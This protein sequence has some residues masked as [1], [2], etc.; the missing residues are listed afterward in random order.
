MN[1]HGKVLQKSAL[2]L[3]VSLALPSLAFAQGELMLEEIIVTAQ[4]RE[5]SLQDVP[6]SVSVMSGD[7]IT[8]VGITNLDEMSG[9]IPN[10]SVSEGS[11]SVSITMRG[12][13]SG[14]N[15]GFEQSVGM[16]VD[17]I[18]AGRDRQFRS[19]FM[20]V[21]SVE[22]LRGPQGTLFGKNTIAG[23]LNIRTAKPTEDFEASLRGSYE[24]ESD[25]YS[26]EGI[27]SG[28]ISDTLMGRLAVK[29]LE[30]DGFMHNTYTGE[31]ESMKSELI[32][33]GTL[34]WEPTDLLSVITKFETAHTAARGEPNRLDSDGGWDELYRLV[35]EDFN[36]ND[37][38]QRSTDLTDEN[39]NDSD[40]LTVTVD[41]DLNE[42]TLTSITGYS[43][44]QDYVQQDVDFSPL[45]VLAQYQDQKFDQLSQE[46][47]ITSPL[48]DKFDFLAGAYY[49]K[50]TLENHKRLDSN[51]ASLVGGVP[52]EVN[53]LGTMLPINGASVADILAPA[54]FVTKDDGSVGVGNASGAIYASAISSLNTGGGRVSDYKQDAET[55]SI[56][57]QGTWHIE[58]NL[59]LTLGLRYAEETK[60]ASRTLY[61][62]DYGTENVMDLEDPNNSLVLAIQNGV[63]G[64]VNHS[65]AAADT[66]ENLSPSIKLQYE[67]NDEVMFYASI[68]QAF[69]S[70]GYSESGTSADEY[71]FGFA[72]E[73]ALAFEF[74]SKMSVMD[75]RG[76]INFALF[77][78]QYDDLQVSAFIGDRYVVGN[79]AAAT[80]QGL[81]VDGVFRLTESIDLSGSFAYLDA[82]YDEFKTAACTT[83]QA[84]A[85]G[86]PRECTQDLSGKTLTNAPEFSA[87]FGLKHSADLGDNYQL[88]STLMANYTA[89]Q[90]LSQ[91]LDPD[92][93]E[94]SHVV[95]SAR[96]AISSNEDTWE[97]ALVG[98]NLTN[99]AIRGY[100]AAV[101]L[102]DG[103]RF[104]Y[105]AAPRTLAVQFLVNY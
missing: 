61:L 82:T 44:Y 73:E 17:G 84:I 76:T 54:Q 7:A 46:F 93:L 104:S 13:G 26:L 5:Q 56:Y 12:L 27:I 48:G 59:H 18:Y 22:V 99:E 87:N 67:P 37:P 38:Y 58:D 79:A 55:W 68:S 24:P 35:D 81:E 50:S 65:I 88:Y 90:Y 98:K 41:Y 63:F 6:V 92:A 74:G 80:S 86:S 29:R 45:N 57:G 47:R 20:D 78:T 49:Q 91:N 89:E 77:H 36:N 69:K 31:D 39:H 53:Y 1:L 62:S 23:A 97:L 51:I 21:E 71:G 100:S 75:G 103:A 28:E 9:Y 70:G 40:S 42:Y 10:L 43:K 16:F 32:A 85:S 14:Q 95:F 66:V 60:E 52:V 96:T 19:P 33:R 8:E 101:P 83:K 34:V 105:M 3:A 72:D 102:M 25:E 64:S 30:A 11:Q 4:K 2:A 94:E 15:Q